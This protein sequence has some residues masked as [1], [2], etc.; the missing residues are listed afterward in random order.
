MPRVSPSEDPLNHQRL[1]QHPPS[2]RS[3][4]LQDGHDISHAVWIGWCRLLA[5]LMEEGT[6]K[7]KRGRWRFAVTK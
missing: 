1:Q 2:Q 5:S 3:N 4:H 7:A 6:G